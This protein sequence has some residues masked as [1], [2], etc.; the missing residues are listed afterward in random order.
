MI[1]VQINEKEAKQWIDDIAQRQIPFATAKALTDTAA[2]IG[3]FAAS[4]ANATMD[5][6]KPWAGR[7]KTARIGQPPSPAA[8]FASTPASYKTPIAKMESSVGTIGWQIAEQIKD[9]HTTRRPLKAKHRFIPLQAGRQK[10]Q[11]PKAMFA[12]KSVFAKHTKKGLIM[13][14]RDGRNLKPLYKIVKEQDIAP[15]FDFMRMAEA[16]APKVFPTF[17]TRAMLNAIKTAR[18]R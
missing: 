5:I 9:S 10:S 4:Q 3:R 15:K 18:K 8:A 13:F 7:H 14:Q 11:S 12:K 16:R 6:R 17:F 2:H 1:T